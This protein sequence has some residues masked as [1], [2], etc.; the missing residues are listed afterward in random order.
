M[1]SKGYHTRGGTSC[2][3]G[4]SYTHGSWVRR[5]ASAH[6][7]DRGRASP[8]SYR[9]MDAAVMVVCA[10]WARL[11]PSRPVPVRHSLADPR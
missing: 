7:H 5:G 3:I 1:P 6:S 10:E 11:N 8:C 4:T 9:M 2:H